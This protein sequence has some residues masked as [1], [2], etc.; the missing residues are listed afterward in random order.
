MAY[1]LGI[2]LGTSSLKAALV[3][4]SG[5]TVFG[6]Q[7]EARTLSPRE[8]FF[9]VD[10]VETWWNGFL[11][12]CRETLQYAPAREIRALCVSSVCGS[13]VPVDAHMAPL[14]NAILYGIDRRSA[15][16][17]DEL[18]AVWGNEFLQRK[19]GGFFTTHSIFPKVLW[20]KRNRPEIYRKTVHFV[21]SFNFVAARLTGA[22]SWDYPTAFGALM[23]DAESLDYPQW[24]LDP[25]GL[26]EEKFPPLGSGLELLGTLTSEAAEETGLDPSTRVMRGACD[27]NTEAMAAD[28]VRPGSAIAVFGST[29]SLLLNTDQPVQAEGF[30]PGVSLLPNVWRIGAATSSGA[31][32][33]DWSKQFAQAAPPASPTGILFIPYL[34][35][36]RSPFNAPRA[37]GTLL[38][39]KSSHGPEDIAQA[40][41][42]S[43][44]YE[45]A[46]L[47]EMMDEVHPFPETLEITGGLSRLTPLMQ[48]VSDITGRVLR[49]HAEDASYG[50]ARIA[51]MADIP[52]ESLPAVP[53]PVQIVKPGGR[54]GLYEPHR[55]KFI[56][57]CRDL[58][59]RF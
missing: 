1:Y 22:P 35:G 25:E 55:Q 27:I 9:E 37:T 17:A 32:T 5:Q 50:S 24:F 23:L 15:E 16:I 20:L 36:A 18:N 34:D 39:L 10:P 11:S 21:S 46:L 52:Y 57:T 28:A 48:T 44:G 43:L 12:L 30:V 33:I 38:G 42:E 29:L 13:F 4:E 14:H 49:V 8:G 26:E 47:I 7:R 59:D 3:D 51:M 56:R 31:R 40:V 45:L 41:L 53:V 58:F 6:T 54:G 19:L 2:D